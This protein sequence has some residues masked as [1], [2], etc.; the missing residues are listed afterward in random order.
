MFNGSFYNQ[1]DGVSVGSFLGPVLAKLFISYHEKKWLQKVDKGKI[2]P[3]ISIM[4]M[5]FFICFKMKSAENVFEFLN[6]QHEN[7]KLTVE[8]KK[9]QNIFAN[10]F[11]K[12]LILT[13]H[14]LSVYCTG[15][16]KG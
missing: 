15:F 8:K 13:L 6:C 2:L 4:Q 3:C 14:R 12:T 10:A 11:V 9:D 5:I 7:I 1:I 16:M